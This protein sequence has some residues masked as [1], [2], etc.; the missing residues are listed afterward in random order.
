MTERLSDKLRQFLKSA[1]GREVT[2]RQ[3]RDELRI[4]P[5]SEAWNNVRVYMHRLVAEKIVK[6]SGRNDGVFKVLIPVVPVKFTLDGDED[7]GVIPFRFPRSYI[8]D[9]TFGLDDIIEISE[10]DCILITGETNYGKTVIA[11]SILGENL[12]L[13]QNCLLMGSEYTS[14][15]GEISKKFKRRLRRM[16]WVNWVNGDGPRFDLMPIE[17]DYEDYVRKDGLTVIDWISLPGEYYLIDSVMKKIKNGVGKGVVVP[18]TQ[19][20]RD[21]KY[22]EGGE[23]SERYADCVLKIDRLGKYESMLT[24]G[25]VKSSKE[26][27]VGRKF[28]FS[29]SDFGANLENIREI[30]KCLKCWTKGVINVQGE[31]KRCHAC[32]GLG[33]TDKIGGE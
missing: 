13:F 22:S 21:A 29:I 14:S 15:E 4:Q 23:R 19:K 17:S 2:L 8:D 20:N 16:N 30:E 33:Y 31:T 6:P 10:G 9:T 18:V 1:E 28:G 27:I 12:D 25:K 26:R 11:L 32:N 7:E 24:I 3:I 5:G